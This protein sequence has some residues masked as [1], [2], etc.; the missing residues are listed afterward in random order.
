MLNVSVLITFL[1]TL[2]SWQISFTQRRM[3]VKL[4]GVK[5]KYIILFRQALLAVWKALIIKENVLKGIKIFISDNGTLYRSIFIWLFFRKLRA[6]TITEREFRYKKTLFLYW[7]PTV[8]MHYFWDDILFI[9][10]V[11]LFSIE[12]LTLCVI[13]AKSTP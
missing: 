13:S 4:T 10:S 12:Y 6:D 9:V 11:S 5:K 1:E 2:I 7:F 3:L 8:I